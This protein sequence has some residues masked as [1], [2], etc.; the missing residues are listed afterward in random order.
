MIPKPRKEILLIAFTFTLASLSVFGV[1]DASALTSSS[2]KIKT[3]NLPTDCKIGKLEADEFMVKISAIIAHGDL[4]DIPFAEKTFK[5]KFREGAAKTFNGEPD[6][7]RILFQTNQ[8]SSSPIYVDVSLSRLKFTAPKDQFIGYMAIYDQHSSGLNTTFIE[9]CIDVSARTLSSHFG[10]DF[11]PIHDNDDTSP[12]AT[13]YR[14]QNFLGKN[15][16]RLKLSIS[17]DY[18]R[19]NNPVVAV[20]ISQKSKKANS[21]S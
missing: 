21:G 13:Q 15:N 3:Q 16:T 9:D 6:P 2:Q 8:I 20:E 14:Q 19:P 1:C 7:Q 4:T 17:A 12:Y 11:V 5:T 10:G 18:M